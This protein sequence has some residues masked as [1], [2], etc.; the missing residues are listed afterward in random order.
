MCSTEQTTPDVALVTGSARGIGFAIGRELGRGGAIVAIN[1]RDPESVDRAVETLNSEG[2]RAVPAAGD[3]SDPEQVDHLVA[4]L[5][6]VAGPVKTL[7]NNAGE[8]LVKNAL[9]LEL[10]EWDSVLAANLTG[11]FICSQRVASR[12]VDNGGG[13]IVNVSSIFGHGAMA[14]RAPYVAAK[15]GL[16]GLTRALAVEWGPLG[17]RVVAV[18]PS[19]VL[20]D[21]L[22]QMAAEGQLDLEP[23][24]RKSSLGRLATPEDVARTVAFLAGDGAGFISG[25]SVPVDGAWLAS[26]GW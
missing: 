18:S 25:V 24:T 17:I 3:V 16:E 4:Q 11:P 13:V 9:D 8:V 7:V 1:G 10:G 22:A 19:Y 12:M 5:E 6:S 26:V 21:R 14:K 20:T 2:L 15:H 23:P